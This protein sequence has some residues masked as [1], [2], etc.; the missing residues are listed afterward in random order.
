MSAEAN[1]A[2]ICWFIEEMNHGNLA[3][4]D[5][6]F[7]PNVIDHAALSEAASGVESIKHDFASIHIAFPELRYTINDLLADG[8]KVVVRWTVH[9]VHHGEFAGIPPTGQQVTLSGT[10]IVRIVDGKV[11]EVWEH[12]DMLGLLHQLGAVLVLPP[13]TSLPECELLD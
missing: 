10:D 4:I 7:S 1:K 5:D 8:D 3:V 13:H 2:L 12:A 9:G 6:V 11:A